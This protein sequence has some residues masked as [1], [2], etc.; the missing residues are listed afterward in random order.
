MEQKYINSV[1]AILARKQTSFAVL[2]CARLMKFG[3]E[4]HNLFENINGTEIFRCNKND[5]RTDGQ[6]DGQT[7]GRTDGRTDRRTDG[8]TDT[9]TAG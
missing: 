6:T 4:Y 5:R 8:R 1:M 9:H 2:N 7:D 3:V